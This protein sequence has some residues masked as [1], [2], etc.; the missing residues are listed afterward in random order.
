MKDQVH[1]YTRSQVFVTLVFDFLNTRISLRMGEFTNLV[2]DIA[3]LFLQ[4]IQVMNLP[5]FLLL[6]CGLSL[7]GTMQ[8]FMHT[9]PR[10]INNVW[11]KKQ[12]YFREVWWY[13]PRMYPKTR[14]LRHKTLFNRLFEK[15][16]RRE[17]ACEHL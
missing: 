15:S 7:F 5:C 8:V 13:V 12:Y 6:N 3:W 9:E 14:H 11:R 4:R 10:K 16:P 1:Q 2:T 17:Q